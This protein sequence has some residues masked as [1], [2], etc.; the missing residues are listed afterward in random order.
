ALDL[1]RIG[2]FLLKASHD[3]PFMIPEIDP[4]PDEFFRTC[5]V[6]DSL[7]RSDTNVYTIEVG[8]CDLLFDSCRLHQRYG[9]A[10]YFSYSSVW[11]L[12]NGISRPAISRCFI[13]V[14]ISS[15]SPSVTITFAILP[16]SIDPILS[17]TPKISAGYIVTALRAS[18]LGRPNAAAIPA[19]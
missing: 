3:R 16:C 2:A 11:R 5:N 7:D 4:Q 17:A 14:L 9:R 15:G 12:V 1:R 19:W 6:V 10:L 13:W 8:R 18:S